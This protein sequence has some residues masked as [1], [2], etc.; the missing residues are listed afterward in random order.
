MD[1]ELVLEPLHRLFEGVVLV[2]V[3]LLHAHHHVAV[4]LDEAAVGVVGEPRVAGGLGQPLHGVVVEAEVED[5]VHHARHAVAG[6]G[7]H[8][9]EQGVLR[10]AELLPG[11][12][13]HE[14]HGGGDLLLE[15]L[16]KLLVV[17][18][19]VDADLGRDR[20]ARG[21][22]EADLRHLGEVGPLAAEER[23]HRAVAVALLGAEGVDHPAWL[24]PASQFLGR[25]LGGLLSEGGGHGD[26][27]PFRR[28]GGGYKRR[29]SAPDCAKIASNLR[30]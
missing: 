26:V 6:P 10:V 20:E 27:E 23:L 24:A 19:V 15:A 3:P 13:L 17:L 11:L 22:R 25:L 2:L 21:H 7:P 8:A 16:G 4:H 18:V 9:H 30:S 28:G 14:L 5:R 1:A 12:L 29:V